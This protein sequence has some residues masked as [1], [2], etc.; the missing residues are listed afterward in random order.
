MM[1]EEPTTDEDEL[2]RVVV[3]LGEAL[4]GLLEEPSGVPGVAGE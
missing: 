2:H 1:G 4:G 3:E